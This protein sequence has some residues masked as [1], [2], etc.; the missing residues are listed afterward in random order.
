M[1]QWSSGKKYF[2]APLSD[3]NDLPHFTELV[4]E[5]I[6]HRADNHSA[7]FSKTR[8]MHLGLKYSQH[9]NTPELQH[10]AKLLPAEPIIGDLALLPARRVGP[11]ARRE[12]QY[13]NIGLKYGRENSRPF[14][15][16]HFLPATLF[17]GCP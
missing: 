15:L 16:R 4:L 3:Q 5:P 7:I 8:F 10:S 12:D 1:E 13:F 14:Y 17:D 11:T 2:Q 9:S 6:H